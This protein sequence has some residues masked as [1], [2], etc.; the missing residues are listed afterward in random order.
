MKSLL[1][2]LGAQLASGLP[3]NSQTGSRSVIGE[4]LPTL[5]LANI[6][7][8]GMSDI[9]GRSLSG[10]FLG[11]DFPDPSIIWGDG[12]WKAYATSSNGKRIPVATSSDTN[13]WTLTSNDALPDPGPWVD[14][15]DKGIWAPDVQKNDAGTYVSKS[16][17]KS[18][19][20]F[21][22]SLES[23]GFQNRGLNAFYYSKTFTCLA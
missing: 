3:A 16:I 10:P 18:Y 6:T 23:I 5:G 17:A 12:S 4:A 1:L 19:S 20:C 22:H 9:R 2:A 11:K 8:V 7:Q 15:N 13:S 14:A 21:N